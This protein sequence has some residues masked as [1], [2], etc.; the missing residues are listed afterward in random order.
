MPERPC[1]S[2][3]SQPA[4]AP[5]YKTHSGGTWTTGPCDPATLAARPGMCWRTCFANGP[6][7]VQCLSPRSAQLPG[8]RNCPP[9]CLLPLPRRLAVSPV[10]CRRVALPA[11][12]DG[13][14]WARGEGKGRP[15]ARHDPW[16]PPSPAGSSWPRGPIGTRH[17]R[18]GMHGDQHFQGYF[19]AASPALSGSSLTHDQA[20]EEAHKSHRPRTL[21]GAAWPSWA[22]SGGQKAAAQREPGVQRHGL[23]RRHFRR[24]STHQATA[25][26]R[27]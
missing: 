23:A 17:E 22:A 11:S 15:Q 20:A 8:R 3:P 9:R 5:V 4:A 27:R 18:H 25:G 12:A 7:P 21:A 10:A 16:R 26:E 2:W 1:G 13:V 14:P 6:V 24:Q 19:R